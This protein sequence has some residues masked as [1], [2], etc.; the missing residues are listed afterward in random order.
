MEVSNIKIHF[1]VIERKIQIFNNYLRL[2]DEDCKSTK[3]FIV[4]R[5]SKFV[6]ICF[7]SGFINATGIKSFLE[8]RECLSTFRKYF[9]FKRKYFE[10]Y[11][12]DS[13]SS[14]YPKA[15]TS[16]SIISS[17]LPEAY[18]HQDVISVKY[19]RERFPA[20]FIRTN[21]GTILWFATSSIIAVGSKS[22]FDLINI[23]C[24]IED[25]K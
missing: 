18:N 12:V 6:Y 17:I 9:G 5:V 24:V 3:S 16:K 8:I 10:T 14:T 23:K 7:Y 1:R 4:L 11:V 21:Y 22:D 2:C 13:I 19:N 15:L 20:V 25:L